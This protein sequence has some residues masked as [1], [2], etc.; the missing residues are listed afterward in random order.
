MARLSVRAI[1]RMEMEKA[2]YLSTCKLGSK[3]FALEE[4]AKQAGTV[5]ATIHHY[6][7]N[8]ED[9]VESAVR[10]ANR[11]IRDATLTRLKAAGSPSERI[12]SIISLQLDLEFFHQMTTR[13]YVFVLTCGI[14]YKGVLRIYDVTHARTISNLGFALR[15]LV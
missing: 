2:V 4:V 13:A 3:G 14:R 11:E 8:K 1:R 6:F 9:L 10:Q 12:W 15:Q 5:K 7:L